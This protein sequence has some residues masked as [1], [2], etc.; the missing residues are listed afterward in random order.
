MTSTIE[1]G[2]THCPRCAGPLDFQLDAAH[3]GGLQYEVSCAPCHQIFFH[4]ST[5]ERQLTVAA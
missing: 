3:G 4:M 1:A 2:T 5:S